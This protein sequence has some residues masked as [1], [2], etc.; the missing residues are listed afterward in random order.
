MPAAPANL[1]AAAPPLPPPAGEGRGESSPPAPIS[2]PQDSGL[3]TQDSPPLSPRE[4]ALLEALLQPKADLSAIAAAHALS[5]TQLALWLRQPHIAEALDALRRLQALSRHAWQQQLTREA[6]E[7]L[8]DTMNTTDDPVERRRSA[9]AIL[10]ALRT[11]I[12]HRA[13]SASEDPSPQHKIR[14]RS[15]SEGHRARSASEGHRARSASEGHGARSASEGHSASQ[16]PPPNQPDEPPPHP[17]TWQ[18]Q[19]HARLAA[20]RADPLHPSVLRA[21]DADEPAPFP[22]DIRTD[23]DAFSTLIADRCA[24]L[25]DPSPRRL[26]RAISEG[27]H[28]SLLDE[29][30]R[31]TF[32]NALAASP[33]ATCREGWTRTEHPLERDGDTTIRKYTWTHP[34]GRKAAAAIKLRDNGCKRA[35]N[36]H[37]WITA[38]QSRSN[39]PSPPDTS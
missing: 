2:L 7:T 9:S 21:I 37:W 25:P 13:R 35:I 14:A 12:T 33:F 27:L 1:T 29:S 4:A 36:D 15:A 34:D 22:H 3:R 31:R 19:Q 16:G 23:P 38:I 10:R 39:I 11:P 30:A 6:V 24:N 28:A 5:L 26:W 17:P 18:Q 20:L 8:R 32:L